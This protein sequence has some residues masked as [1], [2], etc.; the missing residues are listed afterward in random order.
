LV[1]VYADHRTYM[2]VA[3]AVLTGLSEA[4]RSS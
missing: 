2:R 1:W 3:A 4:L